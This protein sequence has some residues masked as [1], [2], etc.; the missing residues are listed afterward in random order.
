MAEESRSKLSRTMSRIGG[1]RATVH[2]AL[3][4]VQI[5]YGGYY[6]I[7]KAAMTN[8]VDKIVFA[9]YRDCIGLLFLLPLAHFS[10][11]TKRRECHFTYT[12][13][14]MVVAL[15]VTGIF[16]QQMLFLAGLAYTNSGFAAAMQNAIPVFTFMIA[17]IFRVEIIRIT[18]LDGIAKLL[19]IVVCVTG[20]VTMSLYKGPVLLGEAPSTPS[21]DPLSPTGAPYQQVLRAFLEN[22]W[23]SSVVLKGS[24]IDPWRFGALCLI[25]NCFCMGA[26]TN[27]QVPALRRFPAPVT[28]TASSILV[29]TIALVIT[30][31]LTVSAE[32]DW[33]LRQPGNILSVMYAGIVASGVNFTLQTWSNQR[34]GPVLVATYIPLQTF[35]SAVL[36]LIVL[37][38]ALYL[39]TVLGAVCILTGLYLLIWGQRAHHYSQQ[40][41]AALPFSAVIGDDV[42]E[43]LLPQS[44]VDRFE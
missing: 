41:Q 19:G 14:L 8:G 40:L 27:L 42:T 20:A 24:L 26:Y 31:V 37:N 39:G 16:L 36:G 32:S 38:E 3:L 29:G 28:L 4:T 11:R 21:T 23:L 43:P 34:G 9:V 22:G 17:V 30:G 7:S 33:V 12:T 18:K 15:G 35:F 44:D 5:G 1:S 10:E 6:V 25:A 13:G 2:L